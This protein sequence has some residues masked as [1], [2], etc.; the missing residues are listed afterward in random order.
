MK[1]K[2]LLLIKLPLYTN[3]LQ[4][5][6]IQQYYILDHPIEFNFMIIQKK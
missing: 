2:V 1:Q 4:A 6:I 5:A 3:K